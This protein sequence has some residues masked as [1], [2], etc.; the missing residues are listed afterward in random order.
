ME[1]II[2]WKNTNAD[3]ELNCD[4]GAECTWGGGYCNYLQCPKC[5]AIYKMPL[6]LQPEKVTATEYGIEP[7]MMDDGEER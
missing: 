5:S 2:F 4:C 1:C 7:V 6:H 3:G